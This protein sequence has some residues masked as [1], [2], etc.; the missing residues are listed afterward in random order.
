MRAD[1]RAVPATHGPQK[2]AIHRL[3]P[4]LGMEK[5]SSASCNEGTQQ[6]TAVQARLGGS[7]LL[8]YGLPPAQRS[9]VGNQ[10]TQV[11]PGSARIASRS[12]GR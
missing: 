11:L 7:W 6:F 9:C 2:A 3:P 10:E 8:Q 1:M 12:A 4:L 5:K